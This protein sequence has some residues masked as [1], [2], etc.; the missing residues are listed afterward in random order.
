VS[1]LILTYHAV[2]DG[3]APLCVDRKTFRSHLD[4]I[5]RSE[6]KVLTV[7]ELAEALAAGRVPERAVAITFDDGFRSVVREA[8]PMLHARGMP[9][10]VFAVAGHLG[11]DNHWPTQPPRAPRLPLAS[12]QALARLVDEDWEVGS[13]GFEHAPLAG[14][15]ASVLERELVASRRRLEEAVEGPVTS[16]AYPYGALPGPEGREAVGAAY[17]VACTTELGAIAAGAD[18][19]ALQRVEIHYVRRPDL[20][21]RAIEGTLSVY[22][23]ARRLG[24]RA[25]RMVRRDYAAGGT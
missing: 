22:L 25:R 24:A 11:G 4:V 17:E 7:S 6:A 2:E 13:H 10:T 16:F 12:A 18:P 21:A 1:A 23:G 5:G 19:L 20:L 15:G 8:A 14:A 3:P 9:A